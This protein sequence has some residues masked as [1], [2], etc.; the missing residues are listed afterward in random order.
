MQDIMKRKALAVN[1]ITPT[2]RYVG[3]L[4]GPLGYAFLNFF[5][6]S[7]LNVYY[8]DVCGLGSLWDGKFMSLYPI[9]VKCASVVTFLLCGWL[10]DRANSRWGKARPWILLSALLVPVSAFLL[11]LV[12]TGS[13]ALTAAAVLG[14]NFLFYAVAA[15]LYATANTLMVPLASS[16]PEQ[17]SQLSVIT[18]TQAIIAG[19]F[20]AMVVPM[21]LIPAIGVNQNSWMLVGASLSILAAPLIFLQ[22]TATRER[23]SNSGNADKQSI[24]RQLR[25]C[26]KSK[27]WLL[28]MGYFLLLN[29]VT[30]LSNAAIF[31]Y[32]NWVLGSY[33]D[34]ITQTL[35]YAIGNAPLGIGV[36]LCNPICRKIGRR[37]AMCGGLMLSVVGLLICVLFPRSLPLVL[38]G[39]FIKAC[40]TIPS[41]YLVSVLLG[42]A[43]DDVERVSGQRCDGFSSSI[44]NAMITVSSGLAFSVLNGGMAALGYLVPGQAVIPTQPESVQLFFVFCQMGVGLIGYPIMAWLLWKQQ[45]PRN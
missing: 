16:D 39:Q 11:F 18:N 8:T 4:L 7:Y 27:S 15:T 5:L 31:Y 34:G 9:V 20:I 33:Q 41:T 19:S 10:V 24:A 35:F 42:D 23:V 28:L 45:R 40:G 26:G 30:Q 37:N 29:I 12:P 38:A 17:R 25:A 13:E 32:C 21:V 44:Y 22:F 36:F 43:L 14:S 1:R 2:E 6:G 3:H